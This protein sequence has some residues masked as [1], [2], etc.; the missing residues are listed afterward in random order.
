ML[1]C[2]VLGF[3]DAINDKDWED[4]DDHDDYKDRWFFDT[5]F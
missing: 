2:L 4:D 1:L 5:K 3:I